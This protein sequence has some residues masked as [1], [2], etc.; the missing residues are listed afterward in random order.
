M[1]QA[2]TCSPS[3]SATRP[4]HVRAFE[5]HVCKTSFLAPRR[6]PTRFSSRAIAPQSI[7][8]RLATTLTYPPNRGSSFGTFTTR[9]RSTL[10]GCNPRT[11]EAISIAP[12]APPPSMPKRRCATPPTIARA[13]D[14][15]GGTYPARIDAVAATAQPPFIPAASCTTVRSTPACPGA[16]PSSLPCRLRH[17]PAARSSSHPRIGG[18]WIRAKRLALGESVNWTSSRGLLLDRPSVSGNQRN[19][20]PAMPC[21]TTR[22]AAKQDGTGIASPAGF[23]N[24][25]PNIPTL[26]PPRHRTTGE[27]NP[28]LVY[29]R[30]RPS[31]S[32]GAVG[33]L[34]PLP[35][36]LVRRVLNDATSLS[37]EF[38]ADW[39]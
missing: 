3:V 5:T 39:R 29:A 25:L 34:A 28:A 24:D 16:V 19:R 4:P 2:V 6:R 31:L 30:V 11:R 14:V 23:L 9:Q 17:T 36:P 27:R 26:G 20:H 33:V 1:Q 18:Y 12:L 15:P 38:P 22:I 35:R 32:A 21:M 13:E 10:T 8:T 37:D 7:Y